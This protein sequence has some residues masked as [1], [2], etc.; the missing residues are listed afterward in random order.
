MMAAMAER[1]ARLPAKIRAARVGLAGL[2]ALLSVNLWTGAPLLAIWVGSQVQGR[3]G[4]GLTMGAVGAVLGT[5]AVVVALLVFLLVRVEAAYKFLSGDTVQPRRQSPWMRSLRDE[6][7]E[8]IVR[9]PASG[10]EK[11][12]I[13]A[14]VLAVIAAEVWFFFFA[15]SSI[16]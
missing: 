15:G 16:G 10:F 4:T 7:P 13:A 14:V 2:T 1:P 11:A 12:M 3:S 6:R 5:L 9:R 8:L